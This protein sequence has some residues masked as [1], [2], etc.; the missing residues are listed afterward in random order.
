MD[1]NNKEDGYMDIW[2]DGYMDIWM[3]GVKRGFVDFVF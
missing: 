1:R 2:M 3:D